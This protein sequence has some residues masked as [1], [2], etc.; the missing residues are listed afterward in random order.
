VSQNIYD[1]ESFFSA[2][3]DLP[4]SILGL[5]GAPEWP[6]LRRMLPD[7]SDRRVIDL[8]CGFGWFCRWAAD[9]GAASVIGVDLSER[10][11]GR[12]QTDTTS[13]VVTYVRQDLDDLDLAG[14]SFDVA[15]SSLTI[16]YLNDLSQFMESVHRCLVP[17][18]AFVFSV[19]HPIY[20]APS[21]PGFILDGAGR[22]VWPLNQ[23][24]DEGPRSTDWLAPG[25]IK[26][27]VTI[28]TY[29]T[30]LLGVGFRLTA[31][32]EWGPD[33]SQ[34]EEVP[35]WAIERERPGFLLVG[36]IRD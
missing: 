20:T 7:L 5:D 16:H 26:Q 15:Y 23:Y 8:G 35:R 30:S 36:A 11:L 13:D 22:S 2:Y 31:I 18:G 3:A 34:I 21:S 28:A 14:G 25:V 10:M 1:D 9:A 6:R 12:A 19:E 32:E 29:L 33:A 27:H 4:R 24:L 17:G